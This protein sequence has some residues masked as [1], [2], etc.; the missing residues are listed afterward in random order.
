MEFQS[1]M[2]QAAHEAAGP[3]GPSYGQGDDAATGITG[4]TDYLG[5]QNIQ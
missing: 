4:K 3:P 1:L 2:I 5:R